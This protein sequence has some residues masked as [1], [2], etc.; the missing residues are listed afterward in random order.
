MPKPKRSELAAEAVR[1]NLEQFA[2]TGGELKASRKRRRMTQ[3][4]LG[5]RVGLSQSTVSL[6]E[7]GRGGSLSMDT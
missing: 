5:A 1:R 6:A 2:R 7:R 3:R 4:Q